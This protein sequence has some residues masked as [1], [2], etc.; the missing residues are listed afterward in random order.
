[1]KMR[2]DLKITYTEK[3]TLFLHEVQFSKG[4]GIRFFALLEVVFLVS[5]F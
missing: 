4:Q 1:M 2:L 3:L 5:W